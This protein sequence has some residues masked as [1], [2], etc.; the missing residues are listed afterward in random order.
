MGSTVQSKY[1]CIYRIYIRYTHKHT[2]SVG[3]GVL[4]MSLWAKGLGWVLMEKP[5]IETIAS[6]Y[7]G[8]ETICH[9]PLHVLIYIM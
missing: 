7:G 6:E 1:I 5:C 8:A 4:K 2:G 3:L 9:V